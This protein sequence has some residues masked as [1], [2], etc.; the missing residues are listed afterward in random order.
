MSYE[1][2]RV[3]VKVYGTLPKSSPLLVPV[4]GVKD[5]PRRLHK[6]AAA[7]LEKMSAATEKDLGI[8]LELASAWRRHR[9]KSKQDYEQTVIK[10]YGSVKEGRKWLAYSSPHETG[11]AI[12]I[13]VGG[14][15]PSRKTAKAQREQPLHKWLVEHAWE[16]G[17][18]PYKREPWHWEYPVSLEAYKSGEIPED[19]EGPP[20]EE[21][22]FGVGDFEDE[23]IEDF[24]SFGELEDEHTESSGSE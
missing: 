22:H 16:Y 14:L 4:P 9:W 17:F 19:D 13:G 7:A 6:L 12:D 1:E 24:E 8:K 18:H 11:L 3:K 2:K 5:K 20:E 10:K 23:Y 21:V 15:W